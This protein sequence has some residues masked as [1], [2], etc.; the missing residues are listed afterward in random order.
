M[1]EVVEELPLELQEL[2][3]GE[4]PAVRVAERAGV[5]ERARVRLAVDREL[6]V[7]DVAGQLGLVLVLLVLRL[8]RLDALALVLRGD[9]ADDLDVVFEDRLQVVVVLR[10]Q[11]V[12]VELRGGIERLVV[13]DGVG[14]VQ[15]FVQPLDHL[16]ALGLRQE[17][18]RVLVHR[19]GDDVVLGVLIAD[20]VAEVR[21]P[22]G[23]HPARVGRGVVL[24]VASDHPVEVR[25]PGADRSEKQ[26]DAFLRAEPAGTRFHLVH[27]L[28]DRLVDLSS[29]EG[30]LAVVQR[31]LRG[32][33]VLDDARL[34]VVGGAVVV[35]H[36]GHALVGVAGD[37]RVVVH[38][39]EV[40]AEALGLPEVFG[41]GVLVRSTQGFEGFSVTVHCLSVS[42]SDA[43][44][45]SR[46]GTAVG[47]SPTRG[48]LVCLH[49]PINTRATELR[50]GD[51][52]L[53]ATGRQNV[54][55]DWRY[56]CGRS[57]DPIDRD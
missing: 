38:R 4:E 41:H 36:V 9:E 20:D 11:R 7:V 55:F 48:R 53:A 5:V 2:L 50:G 51:G 32:H 40:P 14:R 49:I 15:P 8:E 16:V 27:E 3:A 43:V 1:Q 26:F 56:V 31:V 10:Q 47:V 54:G 44:T 19:R 35:E 21:P 33:P 57:L 6:R 18:E 22:E 52:D 39:V 13:P 24:E 17:D 42:G 28:V 25:L 34:F 30:V 45:A 46:R 12:E 37:P 29:I 23:V